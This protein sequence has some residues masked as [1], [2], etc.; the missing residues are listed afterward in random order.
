M[1]TI[2]TYLNVNNNG[3]NQSIIARKSHR[4]TKFHRNDNRAAGDINKNATI[5][6]LKHQRDV[7]EEELYRLRY[8]IENL[9]SNDGQGDFNIQQRSR[10]TNRK[11]SFQTIRSKISNLNEFRD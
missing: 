2:S 9:L 6:Q 3:I 4:N 11:S 8:G 10:L 1:K 5:A 7:C